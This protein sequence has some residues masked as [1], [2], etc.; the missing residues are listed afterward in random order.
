VE[1]ADFLASYQAFLQMRRS[2]QKRR[3]GSCGLPARSGIAH[4]FAQRAI[5]PGN[6]GQMAGAEHAH[7][8]GQKLKV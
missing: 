5:D 6:P 2:P 7:F 8:I 4:H 1:L 3:L